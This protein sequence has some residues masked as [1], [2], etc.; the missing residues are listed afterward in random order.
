MM[1]NKEWTIDIKRDSPVEPQFAATLV[2]SLNDQDGVVTGQVW[3]GIERKLL[4]DVSGTHKPLPGAEHWFMALEFKWGDVNMSLSGVTVET[5]ETVLFNGRYR[6]STL[7]PER[8]N[9]KKEEDLD[10]LPLMAPG[11]GDTGSGTGQQT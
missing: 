8:S 3:N 7:T 5:P 1:E 11:D 4:S 6:A 10:V 9:G 2:F